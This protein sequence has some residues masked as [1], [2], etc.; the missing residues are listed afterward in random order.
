MAVPVPVVMEPFAHHDYSFDFVVHCGT[1]SRTSHATSLD[2][3]L[4]VDRFVSLASLAI[5]GWC[6]V[7]DEDVLCGVT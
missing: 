6:F 5:G 2:A 4:L 7:A 1:A 3:D